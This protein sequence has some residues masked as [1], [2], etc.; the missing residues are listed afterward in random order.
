MI[1]IS[2][3]QIDTKIHE[4]SNSLIY[5]GRRTL[6]NLPVI[7][8]A[9][10]KEYPSPEEIARFRL[11][12]DIINTL[13]T[14]GVVRLYGLEHY[15]NGLVMIMEDLAAESLSTIIRSGPLSLPQ[16]LEAAIEIAEILAQIH[17]HHVMHKDINSSNIVAR[18]VNGDNSHSWDIKIIDFG[19]ATVLSRETPSIRNPNILEGT[20]AYM[21]PEQ[22]GRMNRAI[23]YRTDFYSL[24]VT[25]YELLTGQLPFQS[26][27]ALE[28][29]HS[30]IA[31]R[32]VPPHEI[33][34]GVPVVLSDIVMK[35]LAKTAEDRYQSAYGLKRDLEQCL[36]QFQTQGVIEPF[37]LG[38]YDISDKFQIPQKLYGRDEEAALI[39]AAFERVSEGATELLLV[40]GYSGMG[41]T[42]LIQELQKPLV[43]QRGY[44]ISGK[45]DQLQR[46]LPYHAVIQ[47]FQSLMQQLL[48]ENETQLARWKDLLLA[49]L[50]PNGQVII[51]VIPEVELIIGPQPPVPE[52]PTSEAQNRFNLVFQNFVRVFAQREH[53]LAV[54]LDDLQWAD[55]TTIS[56]IELLV[57]DPDTRHLLLIG[58]Y[59][60][61]EVDA[62]HPLLLT[63]NALQQNEARTTQISLTPLTLADITR[64]ISDTLNCLPDKAQPLA[65]LTLNKTNGN[66]FF[67]NEFLVSLYEDK[68]LN[69]IPPGASNE[70]GGWQWDMAQLQQLSIT[71]NVVELMAAKIQ[72]LPEAAQDILKRAAC[73]G[74]TFEMGTLATV[75]QKSMLDTALDLW[76]AIQEGLIL[77]LDD[78]YMMLGFGDRAGLESSDIF[79]DLRLTATIP[80]KFLHDRVQQAAYSL[81]PE[82]DKQALH[83][84]IGQLL[85]Q[86]T[87]AA[88]IEEHV[89]DIANQ[90]NLG[91]SLITQ[92]QEKKRLAELN[93]LAGRKA[94][95]ATAY[96][97]ALS[98]LRHG[99]DLLDKESWR[100]DYELML[101]LYGAAVESAYFSGNYKR[102]EQYAE[103]VMERARRLLDKVG[104]YEIQILYH[105]AQ[106]E[107]LKAVIVARQVLEELGVSLPEKTG[108]LYV[109]R[110]LAATWLSHFRKSTDDLYNLPEMTD[111]H[112]LATMR[113][114]MNTISAAY[115]AAPDLFPFIVLNMVKLSV[116]HGNSALSA[117]GYMT[118]GIILCAGLGFI[119]YGYKLGEFALRLMDKFEAKDLKAKMIVSFYV[120]IKHWKAHTRETLQPFQEG[121]QSGLDTGDIE[122][123]C[124]NA[125]YYANYLFAVGEPL[126]E[127]APKQA[128]YLAVIK[129]FK[130]KFHLTY[131]QIWHQLALNLL[132][133][134]DDALQLCGEAF[135]ETEMMPELI[136]TNNQTA[137]F[138]TYLAKSML[139][140]LF[141]DAAQAIENAKLARPHGQ[142]MLGSINVAEH[143]YYESLAL[144]AHYAKAK[145][146]A[147]PRYLR[148]VR[149]NQRSMRKWAK[150][151]PMN[152]QHKYDLVA[153]EQARV[154]GDMARALELYDQAIDGAREHQYT[155]DL[156]VAY[157]LAA[158]FYLAQSKTKIAQSYML[159]A[160]H[161]YLRWGAKAKVKDLETRYPN[162][163]THKPVASTFNIDTTQMKGV[164]PTASDGHH[165]SL[166]DLNTVI[167]SSQA[168]SGEIV[169]GQ[170]LKRL[171]EIVIENAGAQRG[172]LILE[173]NGHLVIEAESDTDISEIKV[174]QASPLLEESDRLA[175]SIVNY[176]ART[177][178]NVVLDDA[179]HQGQFTQDSY[180]R[181]NQPK[182]ILCAPLLHQGQLNGI[183]YLE[184]DLTTEAFTPDRLEVLQFLSTQ[185]AI[186]IENAVLYDDLKKAEAE[187]RR[188]EEYFRAMIENASDV[189]TLLNKDGTVIYQSPAIE[190]ILGYKPSDIVGRN[191]LEFVH[192]DDHEAILTSLSGLMKAEQDPVPI[193]FRARD[194][195]GQWRYVE[196]IGN[197]QLDNPNVGGIVVNARDITERKQ[198][199]RERAELMTIQRDLALAKEI[200][201]SLLPPCRPA[202]PID[203]IC[204]STPA[205]EMGGDLYAYY[206]FSAESVSAAEQGD[207]IEKF[208]VAVGDVSG[209]GMPAA[210][211]MAVT[212]ASFQSSISQNLSP[213][214]LLS[215]LD[216]TVEGYTGGTRQ[217]CAMIYVEISLISQNEDPKPGVVLKAA[218]A[219]CISPIIR[220]SSNT[221]AWVEARGMPLGAGMGSILGYEE[222]IVALESRDLIILTSDG[223]VEA[224]DAGG[225][226]FGF[227]RLEEAV[228]HGPQTHAQAM[229]DHLLEAVSQFVGNTEPHDDLTIVIIQ[230]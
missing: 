127:V 16:F 88:E 11:E 33:E 113:I 22:T 158:K 124:H 207:G 200:Q 132:D 109:A 185:I 136:K 164:T 54:F 78:S 100:T 59:R 87:P 196:A 65:E 172:F 208:G 56:M 107:P 43:R 52:L 184:N 144:L 199:E 195:L 19:L 204:Y 135:D 9:Q 168:I 205:R 126:A 178:E 40:S 86:N 98:Y 129:K 125:M 217:N 156:A 94:K 34:S 216:Q 81:I 55:A 141:G 50:G 182:S 12:Y 31:R 175:V 10:K 121:Y 150:Y 28:M 226:M 209:K 37:P 142:A 192:P 170:L 227:D 163:L 197:N 151:A 66:P 62:G 155:N 57:S 201:Q 114:L 177:R 186:S 83:R 179:F 80:Y 131:I 32:P 148:T 181:T 228:T 63:L 162:L 2:G 116:Q 17:Q 152:Y 29:V 82:A 169:L 23:D 60:S 84:Q 61:N 42:A 218:N 49:A 159:D 161:A 223:V 165:T 3:Y 213:G 220:R 70:T 188:S 176:V 166:L 160:R 171:M 183:L 211:L 145:G 45:F 85:L 106:N 153:A 89:F 214:S 75:H 167:K 221:V 5:R 79:S 90:L 130:Q 222:E 128:Q 36:T 95:A 64:L 46:N 154:N 194:G 219:G 189:I 123:A 190:P 7:L 140:F 20:L 202:W 134:A 215:R 137:L 115:I 143:N 92:P 229:L 111:P 173:K 27:D 139:A 104:I 47:A 110:E 53:P 119:N 193:E 118:Y 112:T 35:L 30:H 93:L 102:M 206:N 67:V 51:D 72:K 44:F 146:A 1:T 48:T 77:P 18:P 149:L 24:G 4:S 73:I 68:W 74:N 58:A 120:T 71:D 108:Q 122:Y 26:H 225:E 39:M 6:D 14:T 13:N 224:Q 21:S 133:Q 180:I 191:M 203:I 99:I 138:C 198:A 91:A 96:E 117:F 76:Q 101:G 8:K 15:R 147:R 174:L 105:T 230:V 38:R 103:I 157:E 97:S 41:K 25:F 212:L 187:V 210:L 69:F